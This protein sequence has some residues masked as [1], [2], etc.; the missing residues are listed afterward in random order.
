MWGIGNR[1]S[2]ALP[3][4]IKTRWLIYGLRANLGHIG[5]HPTGILL[6]P[7][8]EALAKFSFFL[9]RSRMTSGYSLF[10]L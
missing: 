10:E 8:P 7:N 5:Q 2:S 4:Y 1:T 6:F 3:F 9:L